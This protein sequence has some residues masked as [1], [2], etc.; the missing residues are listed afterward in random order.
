LGI[1][2]HASAQDAPQG[3]AGGSRDAVSFWSERLAL[4]GDSLEPIF[5][6]WL[7]DEVFL[8]ITWLQVILSLV[9]LMATGLL[10][11]LLRGLSRRWIRTQAAQEQAPSEPGAPGTLPSARWLKPTLEAAFAPVNLFL[12]VWGF[13]AVVSILAVH[14]QRPDERGWIQRAVGWAV[15]TGGIVALFWF[16]FRMIKVVGRHLQR[17]S[18]RTE[19][20]WDNIVAALVIRALRLVVP[21]AAV[22]LILP[23]LDIP[24]GAEGFFRR[25]TSL[26]L[27]GA[28]GYIAVQ[29][30]KA[31]E[32]SVRQQYRL[33]VADNLEARKINT[34]VQ[35]LRKLGMVLIG[36]LT[37]GSMLMVF[38]SVR[39]FG[40][41]ILASAGVVGIIVG[42]AAQRSI[43]TILAG[44]Q[45]AMTQPIRMD[46]VVIVENEWGRIEEITLTYVVVRL[47]DLRRLI[48]PINYFIEKPFQNWTRVSADILGAVILYTDYTLP[49]AEL[50]PVVERIVKASPH[51]DGKFWN[52]QVTDATERGMQ[53]RVLCT[54]A[55]S[56]KAFDLRCDI[57]EKLLDF[58]QQ[59][60]PAALP[61]VRIELPDGLPFSRTSTG[62][63]NVTGN[64]M[65]HETLGA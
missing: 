58:L 55:N 30:V 9:A 56:G 36:V 37:V 42:F 18:A 44:F 21:L 13:V 17:W 24:P 46:D 57:R 40:A 38:E 52:L 3:A 14:V 62:A 10:T 61:R 6:S 35:V 47:W 5:G 19:K 26:L 2:R 33:D 31:L 1:S 32:E 63:G 39:Q 11:A 8:G 60:H 28:L 22:I 48:V 23:T 64:S 34:Q 20:K 16:L 50:R 45:I 65:Q 41:S 49:V 15:D 53:L 27:I 54:A 12:W 7:Q 51:W 4:I 43:A 25:G 29:L 59:K